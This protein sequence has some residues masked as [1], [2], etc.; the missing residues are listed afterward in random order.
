MFLRLS[1]PICGE[2]FCAFNLGDS[3]LCSFVSFVVKGFAFPIPRDD[4]DLLNPVTAMLD[5][6]GQRPIRWALSFRPDDYT[7]ITIP[8]RPRW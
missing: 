8:V 6:L 1:A 3:P 4:G 5:T 2:R 7:T